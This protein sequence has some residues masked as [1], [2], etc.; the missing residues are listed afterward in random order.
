METINDR[1]KAVRKA[2]KL[3][4]T[5][6][7]TRIGVTKNAVVNMEI[8]GRSKISD[9]YVLSICREFG[10]REEWIRTGNG[11]MK[12]E[13][14]RNEVLTEKL[15][16]ILTAGDDDFRKRLIAVLAE[17][18]SDKWSILEEMA[19]SVV[20]GKPAKSAPAPAPRNVHDWTPDKLIEEA[21]R[22]VR[23]EE[24]DRKKGTTA[25]ST[26]SLNESGADCG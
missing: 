15:N 21:T 11:S 26:G 22:Q 4:Q 24:A 17:L 9:N 1:I 25:Q 3:T 10:I 18:P 12:E 6:F 14:P 16:G 20:N 23:A 2:E 13:K 7:G 5:E 8:P 19:E